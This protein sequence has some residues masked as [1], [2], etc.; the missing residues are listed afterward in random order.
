[1]QNTKKINKMRTKD[2]KKQQTI[3]NIFVA[4]F[5]FFTLGGCEKREIP[6][7][8]KP[9]FPNT[10][11]IFL[12][13]FTPDL[14][15]GAFGSSDVLAFQVD[16]NT[17]YN[18][19]SQS[20]RFDVPDANS[21][22]GSYAGGVFLSKVGRNLS[23]YNCLSF[24]I[25]ATQG[26]G[27]GS[28]GFGND[29]GPLKYVV[30]LSDYPV[31]TAWKKVIIPIP[32]PSRLT[33][34][35]GL[36]YYAAGPQMDK[37]FTFWIDELKF[38]KRTDLGIPVNKMLGGR[39]TTISDAAFGDK[40]AINQF[41]S[42]VSLPTGINQSISVSAAYFSFVSSNPSVASVDENGVV[43]IKDSTGSATI[44]AR[45]GNTEAKGSLTINFAGSDLRPG[46][47]AAT[48]SQATGNVISVYSDAYQ[49]PTGVVLNPYWLGSTTQSNEIKV[50]GDNVVRYFNMNYVAMVLGS[51]VNANDMDSF[52]LDFWT[53]ENV[54]GRSFKI[55][56]VDFGANGVFGGGD[57]RTAVLNYSALATKQWVSIDVP[58]S[59]FSG[60]RPQGNLAQVVF[61]STP[62]N[63][64]TNI[65]VDNV[66]LYKKPGLPAVP[67]TAA[68]S[69]SY[70]SA[71]V[72]SLFSEAYSNV[73]GTN[74]NP[75][76]GQATVV[77]QPQIAG[78]N[79]LLYS[80]LNY[81][82][83]QI[84]SNQDVSGMQYLHLDYYSANSTSMKIFLISPGPV[85]MPY[86]LAVPTASGW[87]S[88]DIPLSAFSPVAL[89][90]V[91]Q[92]KFEGNGTIYL[93]NILFR[94]D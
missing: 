2:A 76:W 27:I 19:S 31:N 48:P 50:Q 47:K 84:G 53:P 10:G 52:H 5:V 49:E 61:S 18:N 83:L 29:F 64:L 77:T 93:D 33:A 37:A 40:I 65:F 39:D 24:Y 11:N 86:T 38:E 22:R 34:E 90:N 91:F 87:N 54:A 58:L 8:E 26:A 4:L 92:L 17:T 3:A 60:P 85:E 7:L 46:V 55:E 25:K 62:N 57:D 67:T 69:P 70:P 78:N 30:T 21:P 75:N 63:S 73:A 94:K 45:V 59:G 9:G 66:Y 6:E 20:M 71:N 51:N 12:D 81:Q 56:L 23:G 13:D 89:N 43:T 1:L 82:G 44:T 72:I 79:T 32:D 80:G 16:R 36:F 88:V 42:E 68:P 15:Y 41:S 14:A 28:L 74:L 35:K